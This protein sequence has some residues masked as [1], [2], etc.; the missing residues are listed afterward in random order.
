MN[1]TCTRCGI[2][3][4]LDEFHKSKDSKNGRRSD[5]KEC[6][7]KRSRKYYQEH[8]DEILENSKK[9][10]QEH[11]EGIREY[12]RNYYQEH[13]EETIERSAKYR[14]NHKD[15]LAECT[16]KRM[17]YQSMYE[18]K[19]CPAYLGVVI[20]ER[21]CRHLFKDIEVMPNNHSGYDFICGKNKKIDVKSSSI[22]LDRSK[23]AYW[24]FNIDH[25]TTADFF[26]CVAF[27]NRTNLTPL[28]LFMIPGKEVNDQGSISSTL[29]RIHKWSHWERDI[30]DAQICCAEIKEANHEI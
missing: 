6:I 29:S 14:E 25:N 16:R 20:A 10:G 5:C 18:N 23:H 7:K 12:H 24:K 26:I 11:R 9:Y 22:H 19:L 15:H 1:K 2:S 28:H 3:K 8:R 4:P 27:D 13:R 21:L 30:E 17:G